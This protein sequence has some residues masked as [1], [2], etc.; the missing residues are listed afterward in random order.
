[1]SNQSQNVQSKPLY[2]LII[3]K[4]LLKLIAL[5]SCQNQC[6]YQWQDKMDVW[7]NQ[8]FFWCYNG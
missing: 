7:P 2:G 1:M 3:I 8:C 6:L 4:P 5:R